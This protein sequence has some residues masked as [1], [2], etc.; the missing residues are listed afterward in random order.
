VI[1]E[2]SKTQLVITKFEKNQQLIE[3]LKPEKNKKAQ[4]QQLKPVRSPSFF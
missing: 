2:P 1:I 4:A 3:K